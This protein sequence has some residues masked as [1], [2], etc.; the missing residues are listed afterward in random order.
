[1]TRQHR[2]ASRDLQPHLYKKDFQLNH[3]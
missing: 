3:C 1:M 2:R